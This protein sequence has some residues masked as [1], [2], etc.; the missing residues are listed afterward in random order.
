M[1]DPAT[2]HFRVNFHKEIPGTENFTNIDVVKFPQF[3]QGQ[4]ERF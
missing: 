2:V 4:Y 1:A 3:F